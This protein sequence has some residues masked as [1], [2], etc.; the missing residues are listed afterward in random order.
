M[1]RPPRLTVAVPVRNGERYLAAA[2]E[3]LLAQTFSDFVLLIGDNASTDATEEIARRYLGRDPRV[4]YIR[5][6][7]DIGA[8]GNFSDLARRAKTELFRWHSADDL[9]RP[10][11][12]A[13]CVAALDAHPEAVLAYAATLNIDGEGRVTGEYEDRMHVTDASPADRFLRVKAQLVRCNAHYGVTRLDAVRRTHLMGHFIEADVCFL[14]ELALYG[15]FIEVPER[16]FL[17]RYHGR[18]SSAMTRTQRVR[19]ALG[20]EGPAVRYLRH[21]VA[22]A[23]A[24]LRAPLPVDD[25]VRLTRWLLS[26][27]V[28]DWKDV[29]NEIR[30]LA[31]YWLSR[32][33]R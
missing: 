22:D 11:H 30:I 24:I 17:R 32:E 7:V 33:A 12:T 21:A 14:R 9:V 2:L 20:G 28:H 31:R 23:R 25:R 15:A 1:T 8:L 26:R 29:L 5:H 16:L 10:E 6:E 13:R 3:S 4:R 27:V 19:F 18:A